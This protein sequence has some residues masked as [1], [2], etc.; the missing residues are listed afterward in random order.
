MIRLDFTPDFF[1]ALLCTEADKLRFGVLVR[2][3][4][5]GRTSL[6]RAA[7]TVDGILRHAFDIEEGQFVPLGGRSDSRIVF[8]PCEPT[9]T[10][11]AIRFET[12]GHLLPMREFRRRYALRIVHP[13]LR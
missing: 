1:A 10:D 8:L 6:Y 12:V 5:D 3:W 13:S 9:V 7:L 2:R 4:N 11:E